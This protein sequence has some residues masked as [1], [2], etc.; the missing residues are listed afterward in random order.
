MAGAAGH[1]RVHAAA[2]RPTGRRI[3][4]REA[5]LPLHDLAHRSRLRHQ[6]R[7]GEDSFSPGNVSGLYF[8][9]YFTLSQCGF[10][11]AGDTEHYF[12]RLSRM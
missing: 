4:R 9:A 5:E 11:Q 8:G 2:G 7:G 3:L 10:F 12:Y 1:Y 6:V